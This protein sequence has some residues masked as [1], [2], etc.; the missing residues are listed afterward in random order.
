MSLPPPSPLRHGFEP[1][2]DAV[3]LDEEDD[4]CLFAL[5]DVL[6]PTAPTPL[7]S[8]TVVAARSLRRG[9]VRQ[10][11]STNSLYVDQ[12]LGTPDHAALIQMLAE[13]IHQSC[14]PSADE[15]PFPF[16]AFRE[17]APIA[18]DLD[19]IVSF[20]TMVFATAQMEIEC[21]VAAAVYVRRIFVSAAE[22]QDA[23]EAARARGGAFAAAGGGA[24]DAE[25]DSS[26]C[27]PEE[28]FAF[29]DEA[30]ST[31]STAALTPRTTHVALSPM[32]PQDAHEEWP[33]AILL[34]PYTWRSV[35]AAAMVLASKVW[36]DLS[37]INIDFCEI[38]G[39]Q[40]DLRRLNKLEVAFLAAIRFDCQIHAATYA[41][42]YFQLRSTKGAATRLK[43]LKPLRLEPSKARLIAENATRMARSASLDNLGQGKRE[44]KTT[45]AS[46][47]DIQSGS[48]GRDRSASIETMIAAA[49][50]RKGEG[51]GL[52]ESP[53]RDAITFAPASV[54]EAARS[55][56]P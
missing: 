51:E 4:L 44:K 31:G 19:A 55:L 56:R 22:A 3:A 25:S 13:K 30:S 53:P 28:E 38:C 29:R 35:V 54:L 2:E 17:A 33:R 40:F 24:E 12:C 46:V 8:E 26:E 47:E 49:L 10:V 43:G 27:Y 14:T 45:A 16:R 23:R 42:V 7:P 36:D 21:L 37:M 39:A 15:Y 20:N 18:T 6:P 50:R 1:S 34:G 32:T 9:M 48:Y 52:A 5:D 11:N 41:R